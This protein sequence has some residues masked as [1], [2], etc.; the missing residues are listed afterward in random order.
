MLCVNLCLSLSSEARGE[1]AVSG[2]PDCSHVTGTQEL[3]CEPVTKTLVSC[4]RFEL[5]VEFGL[6][7]DVCWTPRPH[8]YLCYFGR[9][10]VYV[11]GHVA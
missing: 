9:R 2:E 3:V 5:M 10:N 8:S 7:L 1:R 4:W 11:A 6:Y